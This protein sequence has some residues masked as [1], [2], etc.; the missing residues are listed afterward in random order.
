MPSVLFPD[1]VATERPAFS[2]NGATTV[3]DVVQFFCAHSEPVSPRYQEDR[4]K[5]LARFCAAHG[6]LLIS[7]AK[8]YH[9]KLWI[10][11]QNWGA[12]RKA[13]VASI[14]KRAMNFA[15]TLG[16]IDKNPFRGVS[17]ASGER[18][19]PITPGE[20]RALV[21]ATDH[22]FR[23]FLIFLWL[24]GCRPGEARSLQ[25][26]N[27]SFDRATATLSRH[28]TD[29]T[30]RKRVIILCPMA[31]E[32]LEMLRNSSEF[33]FLNSRGN[34]WKRYAVSGRMKRLR[35]KLGLPLS[36]KLYG[37]RHKFGTD[38]ILKGVGIKTVAVL[39]GHADTRMTERYVHLE[40]RLEHLQGAV[41]QL[42][43]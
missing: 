14:V 19:R 42:F 24:T 18:G 21:A 31:I 26:E 38:A 36:A 37:C 4:E 32:L 2:H 27:L 40:D 8:P 28:K 7:E 5:V 6:A 12:W 9:L 39:M 11:A 1:V 33:V 29:R 25:W 13:G 10:D 20:L 30:R 34:P 23:C 41:R 22:P 35:K 15:V 3:A 17:Y 43:D 16:F